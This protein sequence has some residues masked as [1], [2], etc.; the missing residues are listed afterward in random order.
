MPTLNADLTLRAKAA[1]TVAAVAVAI[2]LGTV[3]VTSNQPKPQ[4]THVAIGAI[5][6]DP[7]CLAATVRVSPESATAFGLDPPDGAGWIYAHTVVAVDADGG[8]VQGS[9]PAGI[10]PVDPTVV[11]VP[12][13]G[14]TAQIEAWHGSAAPFD[15]ACGPGVEQQV[16]LIDGTIVWKTWAEA[17]RNTARVWRCNADAGT[18]ARTPCTVLAGFPYYPPECR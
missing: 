1:A 12:C 18:C 3:V 8:S 11:E 14:A 13:T 7:R 2:A 5:P 17:G 4:R 15:C 9:L 6:S 16:T 10:D